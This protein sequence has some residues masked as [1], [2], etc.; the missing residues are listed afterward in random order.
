MEFSEILFRSGITFLL[1]PALRWVP[2]PTTSFMLQS[3][4]KPVRYDWIPKD[5]IADVMR[6]AVVASEDQ[7][8]WTH[9]GFDME[10][11]EKARE[12]NLTHHK[13]RGGSTISQQTAKNLFLWQGGGYVRKAIEAYFT[14][15]IETL[16]SK[17]RILEMYLNVAEFGP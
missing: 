13:I 2:P 11:I 15:L 3:P 10:A 4:V 6:R 14:V 5:R 7:K 17:Q 8:F 1:A 12:H 9:R 16:W